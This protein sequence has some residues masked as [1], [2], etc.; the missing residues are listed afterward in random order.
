MVK[1]LTIIVDNSERGSQVTDYLKG[2]NVELEFANLRTG[3]YL[4][5]DAV[6]ID[7]T[8]VKEFAQLTSEKV[9]FRRLLEFKKTYQ[10]PILL[11]EG[12]DRSKSKTTSAGAIRGAVSYICCL[13][14]IP[15][16]YTADEA[17]TAEMLY[18]MANQTQFGLGFE[19]SAPEPEQPASVAGQAPKPKTPEEIQSYIVQALPDVGS[20]TAS[21]VMKM[22]GSLR[23]LFSATASDLTKVDGI[24]PKKAKKIV[25]IFDLEYQNEKKR[26]R[27]A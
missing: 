26:K 20:S 4:I 23:T 6:A 9:L 27:R 13:N 3:S 5:T 17:E 21:A 11:V 18:I 2:K 12:N 14:R 10:E 8:T 25:S 15:I 16:L 1:K 24:G 19:V 22:Y 7:R